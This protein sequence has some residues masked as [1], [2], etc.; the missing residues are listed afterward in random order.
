MDEKNR[1]T[2]FAGFYHGGF[3]RLQ[4]PRAYGRTNRSA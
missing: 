3:E 2:I 4:Q 1:T